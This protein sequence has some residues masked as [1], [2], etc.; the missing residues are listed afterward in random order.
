[1]FKTVYFYCFERILFST[2]SFV[3]GKLVYREILSSVKIN[4]RRKQFV[5][6]N[7][8]WEKFSQ[9]KN[10]R[11]LTKILSLFPDEVFPDKV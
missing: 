1:M 4:R 10:I 5:G 11:H 6:E 2:K 9:G 7:F 3:E 8:R